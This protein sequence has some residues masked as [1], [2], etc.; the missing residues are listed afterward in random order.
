[1]QTVTIISVGKLKDAFF[2]MASDEYLKRLKA[3]AKVN[4]VEI[5]AGVLSDNA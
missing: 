2:E 1:M 4:V 3:Y 5:K